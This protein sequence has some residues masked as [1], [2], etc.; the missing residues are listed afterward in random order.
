M[1]AFDADAAAA[2]LQATRAARRLIGALPEGL[3]PRDEDDGVAIQ[4]ALALL[5]GAARPA[6]F[7]I[8]ATS[9]RMQEYLGVDAP[10]GGFMVDAGLHASGASLRFEDFQKP[11]VECELVARLSADL[12]PGPCSLEQAA[13]AVGELVCGIEV[14]EG[15]YIDV[16][17]VG[18]P[19]MVADQMFHAAA[20]LGAQ[21]D[22]DW[23]GLDLV[24]LAGGIS[25][26]GEPRSGGVGGD[27]LGHPLNSLCWLAG[28]SLARRFDGLRAGQTVM[29]G[30]VVPPLWLTGPCTVRV[31]FPPLPPVSVRFT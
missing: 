22:V 20:V 16:Q 30:S 4:H 9:K 17:A 18:V 27:L 12:P 10:V 2:F 23:R 5:A 6:G 7:K 31:A 26:D 15:R 8:G 28:S 24:A 14:V 21:G 13:A 3:A 19:T 1:T 25:I 29:L 11:G